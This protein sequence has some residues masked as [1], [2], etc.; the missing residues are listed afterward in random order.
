MS[1][2]LLPTEEV[3]Q[4]LSK[5]YQFFNAHLFGDALPGCLLT[6]QRKKRSMGYYSV[7]RFINRDGQKTDEIALNPTY[8]AT[9]P[10]ED[11]LSTLGHEMCH[12]WRE[13]T[14]EPPR[15]C[16]HDKAWAGKMQEIGLMPSNTGS[17]GGKSVGESMSHYI[18]PDGLFIKICKELLATSFGVVWFDRY[19]EVSGKDYSYAGS[20]EITAGSRR[21]AAGVQLGVPSPVLQGGNGAEDDGDGEVTG[22]GEPEPAGGSAGLVS[23]PVFSPLPVDSGLDLAVGGFGGKVDGSN[24]KKYS[25]PSCHANVWGKPGLKL[26]CGDCSVAFR[27]Y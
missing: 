13:R 19:S 4:E 16:Y 21:L 23:V 5:A 18:L 10:V 17:P 11:I 15:R 27:E 12:Q 25:C 8:F 26:V 24:R 9:R 20:I 1:A 3:Y 14:G 7:D 6:L 22:Y 2:L